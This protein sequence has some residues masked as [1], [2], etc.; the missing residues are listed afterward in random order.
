MKKSKRF[1]ARKSLLILMLLAAF[2]IM[3][4]YAW[5]TS[6]K[7]VMISAM[8]VNIHASQ[9]FQI[10]TDAVNWK[11]VLQTTDITN[12]NNSIFPNPQNHVATEMDPYSTAATRETTDDEGDDGFTSVGYM[13]MFKGDVTTNANGD[14]VISA[15]KATDDKNTLTGYTAFDLFFK[16]NNA[17]D[18]YVEPDAGVT[19]I[20]TGTSAGKG[21]ENAARIAFAY[22]GLLA[23]ADISATDPTVG[24]QAQA[25]TVED[26]NGAQVTIWEPNSNAHTLNA[27]GD[28]FNIWGTAVS[29]N[30]GTAPQDYDGIYAEIPAGDSDLGIPDTF[31]KQNTELANPTYFKTFK[32]SV[33]FV[34]T[35]KTRTSPD[36][37]NITLQ[38]GI[39]KFRIYMWLE[40]QDWDCYDSASGSDIQWNLI[41]SAQPHTVT[42]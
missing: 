16:T 14:L 25:M 19:D 1:S 2:L 38:P 40:G 5:F 8:D 17:I 33:N 18:L 13:N 4:T 35:L 20:G 30:I 3:S 27:I 32:D 31:L 36:A 42:P 15:T 23:A 11:T 21:M 24:S 12:I 41:L 37:L 29:D 9:G 28:I 10:S 22:Q 39:T 26:A 7:T 34:S 6:N